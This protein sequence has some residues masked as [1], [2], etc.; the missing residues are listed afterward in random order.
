MLQN[1]SLFFLIGFITYII[2][3]IFIAYLTTRNNT[4]GED[5]LMGGRNLGIFL[6]I[7][8][9]VATAIGTGS[10]IGG[11]SKGFTSGFGGSVF[12]FANALGFL[13]LGLFFCKIRK[14]NLRTISEEI[15][16]YY[17]GNLFIRK[18]TGIILYIIT[19]IWIANHING[20]AKYLSFV[21]GTSSL[22]SK[23]LTVFAFTIYVFIGGYMA[24]VWT[25][26]IQAGFLLLG[27]ITIIITAI[28]KAG[29]I[30]IIKQTYIAS[31]NP[32]A[33][34]LYGIG[35]TGFLGFLSLVVAAYFGNIIV[36]SLRMRI[37]TAKDEKTAK[38]GMFVTAFIVFL[39]SFIP[40]L[41]GM[42]AFT[43][44]TKNNATEIFNNPDFA[45]HYMATVVLGPV[46]GLLFLIA[47][48][49]ATMSSADSEVIAGVTVFLTDIYSVF[50]KKEIKNEDIP[51][52]SKYTLIITLIIAFIITLYAN[53]VIGFINTVVG[54]IAPSLGVTIL[55]GRF[56]KKV[57]WQGGV[58]SLIG[59]FIFG[60][61]Y[62]FIPYMN[63]II[64]N[65]FQGPAIPITIISL[66]LGILI[67]LITYIK[68]NKT[69]DEIMNIV[70]E[71][72]Y[73][74][75]KEV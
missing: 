67:S 61:F 54:A 53:D 6:L 38:K 49:S 15:Q 13:T 21:V 44:A 27:F 51:R 24:V 30:E 57:T 28:P 56:Y 19:L 62:L 22:Q 2:F 58:A 74:N 20:G 9:L 39:F 47:G 32:G 33:L 48:L 29:G 42:A 5:Y 41:I 72:R 31:N 52:F 14:Y 46:L 65:N 10:S 25:D 8:T 43:I 50:T 4:K 37:Y 45:F 63:L 60:L 40:A 26:A 36:P 1:N 18:L 17:K 66:V 7:S 71:Q 73:S 11:T 75:I 55:L 3:M 35:N 59:G 68:D 12:G 69:D 16:F 64:N 70:M 34:T 23:I